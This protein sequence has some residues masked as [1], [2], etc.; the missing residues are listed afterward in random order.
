MYICS[1]TVLFSSTLFWDLFLTSMLRIFS[2]VHIKR[3][4]SFP[5]PRPLISILS[6]LAY[7]LSSCE[8]FL[9]AC[10]VPPFI[11]MLRFLALNAVMRIH[12]SH[13]MNLFLSMLGILA[14]HIVMLIPFTPF[15][16]PFQS[17]CYPWTL[18]FPSLW[19]SPRNCFS[20]SFILFVRVNLCWFLSTTWQFSSCGVLYM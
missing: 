20:S 17:P 3:L 2:W 5:V 10:Y 16:N 14:P 19:A 6:I 18:L 1:V 15:M 9:H 8:H 7:T 13:V 11:A 4:S 12:F